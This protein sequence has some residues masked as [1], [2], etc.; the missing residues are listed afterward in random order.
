MMSRHVVPLLSSALLVLVAAGTAAQPAPRPNIILVLAD[1]L[2]YGDLGSYGQRII[3][4]PH[5]DRMA[6]EGIRFTQFYAGSTVCAPSRSVLMT[7]Q[8]LGHTRVRGNA[9]LKNAAAQTLGASDVTVARVLQ[10]AGY[11]TALIGK[12]GLGET[13]SEGAPNLH[14]FDYF[15]GVVNQT[16]A[17]NH[18][19]DFLWRNREKVVLPNVVTA[20]GSVP[21]AGY[22][23]T[24]A[25]YANDLFFDEARAF[26]ERSQDRPFF[27]FLSLTVPHAN[28]ERAGAL[29]D[30]QEVP[31]FGPYAAKDWA[32]PLKGQAAMITRM[33]RGVGELLAQVRRLGL[34]DSTLVLFSSDNGPHKEGGPAYDP[35]FF[36]A[37]GPFSGIKRSLTDGGI[38]V[39][40]IARWPGRIAAGRVSPHVGYFG[41]VMATFAELAGGRPPASPDSLSFVPTLL[42][43]R[44]QGKHEYLYWEFYEGGFNQ[45]VLLEGRWKGIRLNSPAAPVQLYDLSTDPA[46]AADVS[47]GQ[48][49][50][51]QRIAGIMRDAHVDNDHWRRPAATA[52]PGSAPI[53]PPAGA[54]ALHPRNP[55]YLLFRGQPVILV[56]SG[57]H[58]GAVVNRAF[59]YRRYLDT[60]ATDG[61]NLTRLFVG[62]YYEKPGAFGIGTNTL[63]PATQDVIVPWARSDTPGAADGGNTFDLARWDPAYFERL[64]D[65]VT[66]AGRRGIVVEVVLFS[67]YY[68]EGWARSP[69][70]G[71]NNVNA[72]GAV[73]K[74]KANTLDN[75]NLLAE[76]ERVVRRIVAELR[77][78]DNVYYEIQNEPWADHEVASGVVHPAILPGDM[79]PPGAFWKNRVDLASP[80]SLAWQARIA[81]V[82]RDEET[83]L[84]VRHLIAQNYGNHR[85]PVRDV[86]PGVSIL[87]FHY[88]W[89]EAVTLNAGLGRVVSLDETGFANVNDRVA[90]PETDAVYRRQAW[91]FLMA[92]GGIYSMLDYSFTVGHEDGRFVNTAPGGGSPALRRQL[93]VLKDFLHAFDIPALAP[94]PQLVVSSPG[95]FPH[96]I[97]TDTAVGVYLWGDG[98]TVL[99]LDLPAGTWREEWIDTRSGK[100]RRAT[101]LA[102]AG[103]PLE[104]ASPAYEADIALRL[105]RGHTSR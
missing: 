66:E 65:V 63:A 32:D 2:G 22:A 44:T 82:I 79:S 57:E 54:L 48:S 45:A 87:N 94:R 70:N 23:T 15:F 78:F 1:D 47:A 21:G 73:P 76:Q 50:L 31:D 58:Y 101:T 10:Q 68:S 30:G 33:D 37:N 55:R 34:D 9:G 20:V 38:R 51:V 39:P 95:A 62:T 75:G 97:G 67:S 88:A 40:F 69:L 49:A 89:P 71:A 6:A 59:D 81:A 77:D 96:A 26:V 60:L 99:T 14:G 43:Q 61:L 36:D 35:D 3:Q 11:A 104:L 64:R 98:R 12:W 4:T 83:R 85:Y 56:G 102:H 29:G 16:H 19:P 46:E 92:G 80:D 52:A 13:D 93:R 105:R 17:H 28:N 25:Q 41:D 27:L 91:E 72:V 90:A 100:T 86:D 8:H 5:L 103:G 7:G 84:G 42:G 53:S 18:Y 74:E 24:R